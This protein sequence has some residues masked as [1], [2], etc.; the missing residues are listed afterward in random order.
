MNYNTFTLFNMLY[1]V[2]IDWIE[3]EKRKKGSI[4]G[5]LIKNIEK[6]GKMRDAQINAIKVYLWLK[7][8]GKCKKLSDLIKSGVV[9]Q[10]GRIPRY[11]GEFDYI[12]KPVKRYLNRYFQDMKI[13]NLD[14]YLRT[15]EDD[16][17]YEKL[18]DDL[19]EDFEY[20]NYLF[21]L[22]MGAG[23]TFLIAAFIYI[24]LYMYMKTKDEKKYA[25]NFIIIAPPS[26]KTS[27][28]PSLKT[29]KMFN[30][31]WILPDSD[32]KEL[33][34]IIKIEVLDDI[35][36][37]DKLQNQNP[38]LAKINRMIN[39]HSLANVFI[40]N[41][42]KVL[43]E[44]NNEIDFEDLEKS[45]QTKINRAEKIKK[46]LSEIKNVE[47]FLDEAHH[48]YSDDEKKK[49][50]R[51]QIDII[52]SNNNV[53]LCVGMSGT[54]YVSRKIKFSNNILNI[55]EIQ[56][57]VFYYPL[58]EGK[59]NFL[60]T[61]VIKKV[62]ASDDTL[63]KTALTDFFKNYNIK[64]KNNSLSKI[65]F[66]CSNTTTLNEKILPKIYEWYDEN[67]RNR[68]EILKYYK[69]EKKYPIPKENEIHFLN[70]DNPS[71]KFRVVL[72]VAIGTEGWD[73]RS[74]TSV[75][76]PRQKT[77][78][79]FVLQTTCRCL[80]EMDNAKN[81]K[82]L[83]YLDESN[84]E[85][86]DKELKSNYHINIE[87]FANSNITIKE[88]PVYKIKRI[89]NLEYKEIE[90]IYVEILKEEQG[91]KAK[92]Y[93]KLLKEY[94][95]FNFKTMHPYKNQIG[96]TTISQNGLDE[97]ITY[98]RLTSEYIEYNFMDF[99][100]DLESSS[101]GLI[102]CA[103][104]FN[105]EK[106]LKN[107]FIEITNE[108]NFSWII[109]H[110]Q[111]TINDVCKDITKIFASNVECHKERICKNIK[112][113][114]LDWNMKNKPVIPISELEQ[115]V[116]PQNAFQD[117]EIGEDSYEANL[118]ELKYRYKEKMKI[119]NKEKSFNYLPYK[120]DSSYEY[121]FLKEI[122]ANITDYDLEIYYNGYK[123]NEL[124][125]LKISTPYGVYT[126]D[127]LLL[128]RDLKCNIEKVMII[129]TKGQPYET[130]QKEKFIKEEFIK[131]NNKFSY[132]RIGNV[133]ENL[134]YEKLLNCIESFAK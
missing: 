132:I 110:P 54:P 13:K 126:P 117:M 32:A 40:L 100:Y 56:D 65:V 112:I 122:L 3:E 108:D 21:S 90:D 104:L 128:K 121:K 17:V 99:I 33:N 61:P 45:Q 9:F 106:E 57:I 47:I 131:E 87:E 16:S 93:S 7:E 34:K 38:N 109:N 82:A 8:K 98:E 42:E 27:I 1:D 63:V 118:K 86:L 24:D 18:I 71:S 26:K 5:N 55:Q 59:G 46:A 25:Q 20:P 103:E 72:L 74:L 51:N 22:P 11:K 102:S 79:N 64:Y 36:N 77:S 2:S 96:I 30:P 15:N 50:I 101:Y 4:I 115:N 52:N 41:A 29:I 95:F 85:T 43:P 129:E 31:R 49:K 78:K 75:V 94:K 58:V 113:D 19:F 111:I 127:F 91:Q 14:D 120:M 12:D 92:N 44:Y 28:L 105:F 53:I 6:K 84:Y 124:Q 76:L 119:A 89:G 48:T 39:G 114:L 37:K 123:N 60:K 97:G 73:C 67:G 133:D 10:E 125:S 66:Y 130:I 134:E 88:Y 69:S 23:K 35:P 70:L 116:F 68:N 83:I 62:D 80:R 107:I 81:E